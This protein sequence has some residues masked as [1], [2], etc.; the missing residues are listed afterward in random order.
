MSRLPVSLPISLVPF[1]AS[2]PRS[3]AV[4]FT[5]MATTSAPARVHA[6]STAAPA[7][8][9]TAISGAPSST[10]A[11]TPLAKTTTVRELVRAVIARNPDIGE[12][13][14]RSAAAGVRTS[15][16]GRLPDP[17]LR[18]EQRGLPLSRP[19][20]YGSAESVMLGLSQTLPPPGTLDAR[21]RAAAA[22]ESQSRLEERVRRRDL[23][24]ETRRAFAEYYRADRQLRLHQDHAEITARL[25]ELARASYR[26]GRRGQQDVV[27]MGLELAR[28]HGDLAHL[29]PELEATKAFLNSLLDRAPDAPLG[30][31]EEI[32][33]PA[34]S[35]TTQPSTPPARA[36]LTSAQL[37]ITRAEATLAAAEHTARWPSVSFGVDYMYMPMSMY[38]HGYNA[39]VAVNLPWLTGSRADETVA[40]RETL[41]AEQAAFTSVRNALRYDLAQA[42]AQL[43]AAVGQFEV[44]DRDVIGQSQ[45]NL[46]AAESAYAAGNTDALTMLDALRT[47]LDVAVDRIRA[48]AHVEAAAAELARARGEESLP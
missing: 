9:P 32:L 20:A 48:L 45:R 19:F 15:L 29:A 38:R 25:V 37:G 17:Q 8:S 6:Q 30:P 28:V 10:D 18:Y 12:R 2:T 39:M 23:V 47:H 11:L 40:A 42:T 26:A 14:A 34:R 7:A 22:E 44:I 5:L 3:L 31:P 16:A 27:R 21:A 33:P 35:A 24:A 43:Q 46:E 41:R 36:E 4:A 13:R 1:F